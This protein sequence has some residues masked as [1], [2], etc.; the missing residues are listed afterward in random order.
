MLILLSPCRGGLEYFHRSSASL[1][2]R[3]KGNPVPGR[4]SWA[5]L[6]PGDIRQGPEHLG[7]GLDA[8]LTTLLCKQIIVTKS[9]EVTPD[10][11]WQNRLRKATPQNGV[12]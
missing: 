5:T 3:R 7:W 11:T 2:R 10:I 12:F 9:E 8:R 4:Y 6:S 1:R